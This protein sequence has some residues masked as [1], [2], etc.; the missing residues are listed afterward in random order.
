MKTTVSQNPR[1]AFTLIEL[2]VVIAIIAILAGLLLPALAKAKEKAQTIKCLNNVKQLALGWNIKITDEDGQL[3]GV[4]VNP[5]SWIA[6]GSAGQND[7]SYLDW[8]TDGRNTN[9]SAMLTNAL[10]KSAPLFKCPSDKYIKS[11]TTPGERTRSYAMN[12]VLGS[13][14]NVQGQDG[15]TEGVNVKRLYFGNGVPG[16]SAGLLVK[17]SQVPKPSK[18]FLMIEEH[19]DSIDDSAFMF[20]P[21]YPTASATWRNLPASFHNNGCNMSF[22]DSHAERIKWKEVNVSAGNST[23]RPVTYVH[24]TTGFPC[25][26]SADYKTME[27]LMPYT[28]Q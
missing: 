1:H 5:S 9:T 28:P 17:D 8:T 26:G 16:P 15:G 22:V 12:G 6:Q 2:L 3:T 10:A 18:V 23:V 13:K 4:D 19:P 11:G 7:G 21:G 27:D 20:D 24:P 25:L 14:P